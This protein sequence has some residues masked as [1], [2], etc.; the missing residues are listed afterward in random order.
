MP[1]SLHEQAPLAAASEGVSL[2]QFVCGLLVAAVAW[3]VRPGERPPRDRR[4]PK[5]KDDLVWD[6]WDNLFR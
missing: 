1:A 3:E 2:N 5:S 4:Y 6:M